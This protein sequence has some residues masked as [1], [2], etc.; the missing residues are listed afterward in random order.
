MIPKRVNLHQAICLIDGIMERKY[1]GTVWNTSKQDHLGASLKKWGATKTGRNISPQALR[2]LVSYV[3]YLGFVYVDTS[4]KPSAIHVTKAGKRL[5]D[6]YKSSLVKVDNLAKGKTN[7]IMQSPLVLRQMEKLQLTNPISA[8]DCEN[9]QLFPFRFLLRVLLE[10]QDID[11][12]EIAYFLFRAANESQVNEVVKAIREF[13]S[14]P[15]ADR[16]HIMEDFLDTHIGNITL[17]QASSAGYF[18]S[19][20]LSTGIM[21]KF[22]KKPANRKEKI[23]AL[24]IK[25]DCIP[26]VKDMLFVTYAGA[27]AWDF[28]DDLRLWI[29]YIGDPDRA[30][31]PVA[32]S[33]CN[34]VSGERL[35]QVFFEGDCREAELLDAGESLT[36]PMFLGEEYEI[37]ATDLSVGRM[38]DCFTVRP[39]AS[40][41]SW[42]F[43]GGAA[44]REKSLKELADEILLHCGSKT[45]FAPDILTYLS[46]LKKTLG[47][48]KTKNKALRGAYLEYDVYRM[49]KLLQRR[50]VIDE[51]IW[52][53]RRG[54][55]GLPSP[56]PGGKTGTPDLVILIG[57]LHIVLEL[58]TIQAR[59]EQFSKEGASVPD[60]I[61]LYEQSASF[62]AAA[63]SGA[64]VSGVFCAP[65]IHAR[66][67]TIMQAALAAHAP[68]GAGIPLHCMTVQELMDLLLEEKRSRLETVLG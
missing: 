61:H 10:I 26:Y 29:D 41:R 37:K 27:K 6:M 12:E 38:T 39:D 66:N 68:V 19:L 11:R 9:I 51:V 34:K 57:N 62:M 30:F 47:I 63:A 24:Q 43:A 33:I 5:L 46:A 36:V 14:L 59:A 54:R 20:C 31:P 49:L 18:M 13:R 22:Q 23:S 28:R 55:F 44:A 64:R 48:D 60:H 35:V 1:D 17:K 15:E 45:M 2:T 21:E 42:S 56:A 25:E 8:K 32:V 40:H 7:L 16:A 58:T 53:G 4:V 65:Q 3:Q 52:N 50:K 67:T